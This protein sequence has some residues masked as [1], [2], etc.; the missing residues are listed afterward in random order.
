MN[1]FLKIFLIIVL[2][3]VTL[4][5][6]LTI[7]FIGLSNGYDCGLSYEHINTLFNYTQD[8]YFIEVC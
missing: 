4:L 3:M 6:L 1:L 7:Y 8:Q 5:S 2:V